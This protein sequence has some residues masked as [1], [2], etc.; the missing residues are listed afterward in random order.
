M[1]ILKTLPWITLTLVM[2]TYTTLGWV[3]SKAP[4]PWFAWLLVAIAVLFLTGV[5]TTPWKSF[6]DYSDALVK[7]N[8]R[9]FGVAILAAFLFFLMLAWFKVF[10]Q[11]LLITSAATLA[12]ID[13]QVAGFREIQAFWITSIFSL[14]G[15]ALGAVG[16]KF[17]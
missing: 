7:S 3:I 13:F 8:T 4:V 9:S 10:L 17:L 12:R 14:V 5:V 16:G 6:A 15:L 1:S 2:V 11:G